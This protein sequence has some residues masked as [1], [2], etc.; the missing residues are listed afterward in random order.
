MP[1]LFDSVLTIKLALKPEPSTFMNKATAYHL[2]RANQRAFIDVL[3]PVRF[4]KCALWFL[5]DT[6][7]SGEILN[8]VNF[9]FNITK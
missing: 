6:L 7:F 8:K 5:I 4:T 1:F 9:Y 3:V 2:K